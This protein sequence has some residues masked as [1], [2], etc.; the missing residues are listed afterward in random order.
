MSENIDDYNNDEI[1]LKEL[2]SVLWNK[3]YLVISITS[4]FTIASIITAFLLPSIYTSKS[5]LIEVNQ[6]N[7]SMSDSLGSLS[8]LASL[9]GLNLPGESASKSTEAIERIKSFQFFS[10]YFLPNIKLENLMAVKRWDPSKNELIYDKSMFDPITKVWKSRKNRSAK[11]SEQEAFLAYREILSVS[12][13]KETLFVTIKI[14]HFSPNIAKRWVEIIIE[15]INESMR[16]DD[17]RR[18][19]NAV[20]FLNETI[21]ST[22]TK[23]LKDAT[24]NLLESQMQILMMSASDKAYVF[25]ILDAPIAPELRSWPK[26][27]FLVIIGTILGGIISVLIILVSHYTIYNKE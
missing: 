9:G 20:A 19:E 25:K 4:A 21:A 10:Q 27:T 2:F 3:K 15:N 8:S 1:D 26:R 11:P 18:A 13:S 23:S 12:Q 17:K 6:N 14:D 5:I 16:E 7:N 24:S 22:N